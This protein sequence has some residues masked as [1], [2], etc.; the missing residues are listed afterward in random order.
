[1]LFILGASLKPA[2]KSADV[3]WVKEM[4]HNLCHVPAYAVLMFWVVGLLKAYQV[5]FRIFKTAFV[6][7]VLYGILMEFLQG[8]VP[9]RTPSVSDVFLNAAGALIMIFL[10]QR[11]FM[12]RFIGIKPENKTA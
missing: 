11:G 8:L 7:V 6:F 1:M 3:S 9:G 5:K 2:A 12:N 4:L 10:I